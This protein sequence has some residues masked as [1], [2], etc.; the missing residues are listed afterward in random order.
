LL[1]NKQSQRNQT[2][3]IN[4]DV[5]SDQ[6]IFPFVHHREHKN[7]L[8]DADRRLVPHT[9]MSHPLFEFPEEGTQL[10]RIDECVGLKKR[11]SSIENPV[12]GRRSIWSSKRGM[13]CWQPAVA[14]NRK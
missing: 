6:S 14:V 13:F 4:A 2:Q 11:V 8:S 12:V 9:T 7:E 1:K 10:N 5:K 3:S